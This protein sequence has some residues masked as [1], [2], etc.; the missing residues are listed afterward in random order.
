MKALFNYITVVSAVIL[1]ITVLLQ[2]QGTGLGSSFGGGEAGGYRTKRGAEKGIYYLTIGAA[3][4]FL[5]SVVLSILAK[6]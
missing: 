2:N 5:L 6:R 3:V 1:V 4:V